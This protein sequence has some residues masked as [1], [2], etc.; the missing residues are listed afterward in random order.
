MHVI[1]LLR[2][3]YRPAY[4]PRNWKLTHINPIILPVVLYGCET[5]SLTLSEEH[6]LM[7]FENKVVRKICGTKRCEITGEWRILINAELHV[8]YS[9]PDIIRNLKSRQLR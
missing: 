4:F 6:R 5:W 2:K 9:S 1:I 8:L 3:F 7:V